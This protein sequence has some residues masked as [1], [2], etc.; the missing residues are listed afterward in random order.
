M[1]TEYDLL[2]TS[3]RRGSRPPDGWVVFSGSARPIKRR[4]MTEGY[5]SQRLSRNNTIAMNQNYV[6]KVL[7]N[8][9]TPSHNRQVVIDYVLNHPEKFTAL[10]DNTDD[11]EL[12]E[13]AM[14]RNGGARFGFIPE[15]RK[16]YLKRRDAA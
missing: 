1:I 8:P 5:I 16:K 4:A 12:N 15:F 9:R 6:T 11:P 14:K 3:K 2:P 13:W 10:A 7:D